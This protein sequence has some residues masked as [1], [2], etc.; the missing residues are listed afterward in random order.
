[1]KPYET[2]RCGWKRSATRPSFVRRLG[3]TDL[4]PSVDA[5]HEEMKERREFSESEDDEQD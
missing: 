3:S 5:Y 2:R 1:M 4:S